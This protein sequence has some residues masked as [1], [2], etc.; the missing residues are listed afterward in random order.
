MVKKR[1][2]NRI[3][4]ILSI[5]VV[6]L[7]VFSIVGKK[8]GWIGKG[9]EIEVEIATVE[10][11]GIIEKVSASGKVQPEVEL[12]IS[13]DVS[14]EI[15]ELHIKE[16]DSVEKGKLLIRIRPDIYVNQLDQAKANANN[17]KANLAQMKANLAR[18]EA[19]FQQSQYSFNRNKKLHR[20]K[21]ISDADFE[22]SEADF[23]VASQELE[24]QKQ[25]VKAA[26][27]GIQNALA[28]VRV[29][30]DNLSFTR[31]FAP[32]SGIISK[33]SVEQG[34]RVVG[35]S[36]MQGTEILRIAN[37]NNMEVRVDVNEN[38]IIRVSL[39]DTVEIE[40]D[41]YS[42]SKEKFKGLVTAI[43]NSPI[44][45]SLTSETVTEF[46]VKIKLLNQSYQHLIESGVKYPFK[47]GMTASVD[48]ITDRKNNIIAVP[49]SAVTTRSE[50]DIVKK[51]DP[52]RKIRIGRR[53]ARS[54]VQSNE[55]DREE[56][57]K[58]VVFLYDEESQTV[59]LI[60]V[61]TG[62]SDF[63]NIQ[64]VKGLEPGQKIIK[65]PYLAVSKRLQEGDKVKI[66]EEKGRGRIKSNVSTE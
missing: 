58:E 3:I 47:P 12:K 2:T 11:K 29:A 19:R 62:I 39:G 26:E 20:E 6:F 35:T 52:E 34:E 61:E 31:I 14:G 5:L 65:G 22:Q 55:N 44:D 42:S 9:N 28:A 51:E 43:A 27:F 36:Q 41:S 1:N 48:I 24:A 64:I 32:E 7:V 15:T 57:L 4:I 63:D 33:L 13:P 23:K 16:G 59:K 66:K 21:V 8:K 45:A 40:I 60:E 49:L 50:S 56:E 46:E 30:E 17:S 10:K 25:N 37:L 18:A 53:G 38:D 54:T